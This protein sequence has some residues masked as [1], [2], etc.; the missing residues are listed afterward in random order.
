MHSNQ[1]CSI[2]EQM[3]KGDEWIRWCELLWHYIQH[4]KCLVVQKNLG[5]AKKWELCVLVSLHEFP[6]CSWPLESYLFD[7]VLVR[8]T[9]E[10]QYLTSLALP[11]IFSPF[12]LKHWTWIVNL[13]SDLICIVYYTSRLVSNRFECDSYEYVLFISTKVQMV[14][15]IF[16]EILHFVFYHNKTKRNAK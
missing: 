11:S 16:H 3:E 4:K 13:N 14:L 6:R 2:C 1:I 15:R 7:A 10:T 8:R 12:I 5:E 9:C